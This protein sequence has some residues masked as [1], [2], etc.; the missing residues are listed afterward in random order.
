MPDFAPF[1]DACSSV[2]RPQSYYNAPDFP[3]NLPAQWDRMWGF[4]WDRNI[5]PVWVGEFGAKFDPYCTSDKCAV[6]FRQ[7]VRAPAS[8]D[9]SALAN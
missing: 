7:E 6:I 2:A 5:T 8:D 4:L 1:A 3:S 9:S